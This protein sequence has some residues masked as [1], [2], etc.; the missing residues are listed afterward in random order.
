MLLCDQAFHM[1]SMYSLGIPFFFV[2]SYNPLVLGFDGFRRVGLDIAHDDEATIRKIDDQIEEF[3]LKK[4][5]L[6]AGNFERRGIELPE[7]VAIEYPRNPK[8]AS[9]YAY[10]REVDYYSD[11]MQKEQ[12]LWQLDSPISDDRI[13]KPFEMPEEFKKLPGK[14]IYL[15][16]GESG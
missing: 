3:R 14:T 2:V 4:F 9:I 1:P 12:N 8:T 16:L 15:S 7:G 10:P 11:E 5:K 6:L 13:P